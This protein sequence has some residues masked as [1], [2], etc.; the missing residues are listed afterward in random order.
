MSS[1]YDDP[2]FII[3]IPRSGTSMLW[4]ILIRLA[5]F[6]GTGEIVWNT[7]TSI[8]KK[9][10][11]HMNNFFQPGEWPFWHEYYGGNK[12]YFEQ[13]LIESC[14]SFLI[15]AAK[16]KQSKRIL[17]KTPNHIDNTDFIVKVFSN[18]SFVHIYRHPVDIYASM[19]KRA[20]VTAPDK[21]PWLKISIKNFSKLYNRKM[22]LIF[23]SEHNIAHVK[24][25]NLTKQPEM[26]IK[27][28]C[29]FVQ[30]EFD[31]M[32]IA[33]TEPTKQKGKF[34]LQSNVPIFN[35]GY[36]QEVLTEQEVMELEMHCINAMRELGYEK[37]IQ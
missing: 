31:P 4:N 27:T 20:K 19:R 5:E 8:F 14:K 23:A 16:A 12:K 29:Q 15:N 6:R 30:A 1:N 3:G 10:V 26:E 18:A 24:Y 32:C 34:P 7:E 22:N 9:Y 35:N 13:F 2:V 17:E 33:G 25:E 37:H 21:D 36:W 11:R 28:V